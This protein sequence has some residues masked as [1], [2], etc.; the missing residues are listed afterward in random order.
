MTIVNALK[1]P[2]EDKI[3]FPEFSFAIDF[4][5]EEFI[6]EFQYNERDS[7]F[8]LSV[9]DEDETVIAQSIKLVRN[10]PLLGTNIN[11]KRPAGELFIFDNGANEEPNMDNLGRGLDLY[12]ISLSEVLDV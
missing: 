10:V 12:Y 11:P 8:Y 7:R 3:G 6:L 4:D 9:L 1:I 2:L 5:G